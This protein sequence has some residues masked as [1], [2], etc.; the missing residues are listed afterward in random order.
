MS[1]S[2]NIG[3]PEACNLIEPC[4]LIVHDSR[5]NYFVIPLSRLEEF[6]MS[7]EAVEKMLSDQGSGGGVSTSPLTSSTPRSIPGAVVRTAPGA[8]VRAAPGAV[9]RTAPSAMVRATPEKQSDQTIV[10]SWIQAEEAD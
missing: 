4:Q 9:V 6:Q 8:I 1:Q 3:H 2:D 10:R 7:D 5:G